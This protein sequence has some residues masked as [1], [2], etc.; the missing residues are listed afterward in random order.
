M[1]DVGASKR[2][3]TTTDQYSPLPF[4]SFLNYT[5]SHPSIYFRVRFAL[6]FL[7]IMSSRLP[8]T[9]TP[10]SS[11]KRL[12]RHHHSSHSHHNR[13]IKN[14]LKRVKHQSLSFS[15]YRPITPPQ[16]TDDPDFAADD[17]DF[18]ADMPDIASI[19]TKPK[20]LPFE[21]LTL[22]FNHLPH[23]SLSTVSLV[24]VEWRASAVQ[25]LWKT[26]VWT[27][28]VKGFKS[29]IRVL[30]N[31][32]EKRRGSGNGLGLLVRTV[33]VE[34]AKTVVV[35][36]DESRRIKRPL[37]CWT[38]RTWTDTD[39]STLMTS[40]PSLTTLSLSGCTRVTDKTLTSLSTSLCK[41]TSLNVSGTSGCTETGYTSLSTL[42]SLTSL[43]LG[44]CQGLTPL[45]LQLLT[46]SL[47]NLE[48]LS[49]SGSLCVTDSV[50]TDLT[51]LRKLKRVDLTRCWNVTLHGVI[52]F[53]RR[54]TGRV[55]EVCVS[56]LDGV[57]ALKESGWIVPGLV[58]VWE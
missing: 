21:I 44:S 52:Q 23:S 57:E 38:S 34:P 25:I 4:F 20:T 24:N 42:D 47:V 26:P 55:E 1:C 41:L 35:G 17:D 27:T 5:K 32:T 11:L 45:T 13:Q 15:T 22:I 30:E 31:E 7:N 39:L 51:G 56:P 40:C 2:C 37:P 14:S 58:V 8:L 33:A 12:H 6:H 49:V 10:S 50:L 54:G 36:G 19:T 53:M 3:N 43:D 9:A 29:W 48:S 46:R 18:S 28:G 16:D